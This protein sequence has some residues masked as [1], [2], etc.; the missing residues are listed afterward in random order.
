MRRL[1]A[2]KYKVEIV[3]EDIFLWD[4]KNAFAFDYKSYVSYYNKIYALE[5]C[6]VW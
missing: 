2:Y 3:N 5:S 4:F 6:S 1:N